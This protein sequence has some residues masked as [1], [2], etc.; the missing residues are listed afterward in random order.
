MV[1]RIGAFAPVGVMA[2]AI[3]VV[4][5]PR[6]GQETTCGWYTRALQFSPVKVCGQVA[7]TGVVAAEV[8]GRETA[9]AGAG[10]AAAAVPAAPPL[11]ACSACR[12][13]GETLAIFCCRHCS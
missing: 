4:S 5:V 2:I 3:R 1:P 11:A 8:A 13:P 10:A 6:S 12:Q 7:A 9:A